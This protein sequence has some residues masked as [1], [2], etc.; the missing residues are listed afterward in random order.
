MKC[1]VKENGVY[2][3]D[4]QSNDLMAYPSLTLWSNA[5]ISDAL[6][7]LEMSSEDMSSEGVQKTG[8]GDMPRHVTN[9]SIYSG[10]SQ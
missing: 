4:E 5:F 2:P 1:A 8:H 7:K 6:T 9:M 10:L 3:R